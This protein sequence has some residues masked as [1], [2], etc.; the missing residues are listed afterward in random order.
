[1]PV[2]TKVLRTFAFAFL[3]VFVPA[4]A[5]IVLDL[6]NTADWTVA[7]AALLSLIGAAFAAGIRAIVAF[8]PVFA[9]DNVGMQRKDPS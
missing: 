2:A 3:G 6:S 5:N 4:L 7:K 8:L 9:D 1:M